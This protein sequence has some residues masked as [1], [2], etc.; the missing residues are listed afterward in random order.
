MILGIET[1]IGE[2]QPNGYGFRVNCRSD[3]T[4]TI[5]FREVEVREQYFLTLDEFFG[6][7]EKLIQD[8]EIPLDIERVCHDLNIDPEWLDSVNLSL[9]NLNISLNEDGRSQH[10]H[11]IVEAIM[12]NDDW[13]NRL[14]LAHAL[15]RIR[16]GYM[17]AQKFTIIDQTYIK[18]LSP[19]DNAEIVKSILRCKPPVN[20][21]I[22][23]SE[24]L[25]R[26]P[27]FLRTLINVYDRAR[28]DQ[29]YPGYLGFLNLVSARWRDA[30]TGNT[31]TQTR[32]PEE[33]VPKFTYPID[34]WV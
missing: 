34:A 29:T 19:E 20:S 26:L 25:D 5:P 32:Y 22:P 30:Y 27:I 2:M 6:K 1:P 4:D 24:T 23:Y 33:D 21:T 12:S 3:A 8:L 17:L 9:S 18:A 31:M 16:L 28:G 11:E 10:Q 15:Q 14:K 13:V 7:Q